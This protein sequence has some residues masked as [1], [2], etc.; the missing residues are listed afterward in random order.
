VQVQVRQCYAVHGVPVGMRR[1][2]W[3][4][5][6]VEAIYLLWGVMTIVAATRRYSGGGEAE[7]APA[8]ELTLVLTPRSA[9]AN[10]PWVRHVQD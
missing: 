10:M 7:M 8:L 5:Q 6:Q 4:Q 3:Q 2:W 9:G 1:W